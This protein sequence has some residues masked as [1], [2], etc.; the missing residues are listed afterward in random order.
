MSIALI[1]A[2]ACRDDDEQQTPAT[3]T[4]PKRARV[5]Q[6]AP[7]LDVR[8]P[9]AD[10][11]KTKSG[12]RY[13]KLVAN[14]HGPRT[15]H[16][17]RAMVRYTGWSARTGETFFTTQGRDQPIGVNVTHAAP[18]MAEALRAMRAGEKLVF[19][20]PADDGAGESL[21]YEVELVDIISQG[22]ARAGR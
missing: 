22:L 8:E 9:P 18:A 7:P 15:Q 12:L 21:V 6:V 16:G 4:A 10:V 1:S 17:D 3:A 20:V 5:T 19:W 2:A 13:K 14:D 11:V